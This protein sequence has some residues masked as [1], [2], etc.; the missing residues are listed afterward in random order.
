[1]GVP[2]TIE[3]DRRRLRARLP[4]PA[5]RLLPARPRPRR[6]GDRRP[7]RRG[8]RGARSASHAGE[9]A[10][11]KLGGLADEAVAPIAS[12]PI[13]PALATL[14]EAFRAPRRRSRSRTATGCGRSSRGASPRSAATGTSSASTAT[15]TRV[16]AFRADRIEGDVELGEPDAFETPAGFRPDDHVESR[17][18]LLGDDPPVTV[19]AARRRRPPRHDA[20]RS[21]AP[22]RP[23]SKTRRPDDDRSAVVEIAVDEPGRVPHA[24]CSA[25]SST[26]RCSSRPTMRAD[27]VDLARARRGRRGASAS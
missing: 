27:V 19:R 18:W 17:A 25:S 7:A 13:A 5:R 24:S 3:T 1:M 23:S 22:T 11:M 12:L 21:S 10:L 9:G 14:F 2:L 15:A 4:R 8:E 16:R 6:R 26:P 20:R